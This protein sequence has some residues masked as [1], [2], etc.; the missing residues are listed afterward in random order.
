MDNIWQ[1]HA[2]FASNMIEEESKHSGER[3]DEG[4]ER[5]EVATDCNVFE[6]G[7]CVANHTEKSEEIVKYINEGGLPAHIDHI[8]E[9]RGK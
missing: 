6:T 2:V 3:S 7:L 4:S 8:D 1:V 9:K 5:K